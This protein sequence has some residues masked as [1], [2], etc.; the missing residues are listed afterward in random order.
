MFNAAR[1]ASSED[2]A[3]AGICSVSIDAPEGL[4]SGDGLA[5]EV[6]SPFVRPPLTGGWEMEGDLGR[7]TSCPSFGVR[8]LMLNALVVDCCRVALSR[9]RGEG[10]FGIDAQSSS[11]I[12]LHH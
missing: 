5:F 6:S 9:A 11:R 7:C 3:N 8:V 2:E 1:C 10:V 4:Y 12:C